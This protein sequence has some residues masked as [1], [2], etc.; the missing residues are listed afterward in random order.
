VPTQ[1]VS[2]SRKTDQKKG[3]GESGTQ[4]SKKRKETSFTFMRRGT[5]ERG[6]KIET[7]LL[8]STWDGKITKTII[9]VPSEG[10][11]RTCWP[12]LGEETD[13]NE[14]E[15]IV[16]ISK[17]K[18]TKRLPNPSRDASWAGKKKEPEIN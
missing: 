16:E 13:A 12:S 15:A 2:I 8:V 1:R 6:A 7:L 10:E 17:R 5:E 3:S 14:R 18:G 4:L 11:K 9:T